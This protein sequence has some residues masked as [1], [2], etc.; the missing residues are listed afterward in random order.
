MDSRSN[1]YALKISIQG[2]GLTDTLEK[3]P[4]H[5]IQ[6][7][8]ELLTKHQKKSRCNCSDGYILNLS[9]SRGSKMTISYKN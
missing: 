1:N 3:L 9:N 4:D 8:E 2:N 6:K 7:P 5:S